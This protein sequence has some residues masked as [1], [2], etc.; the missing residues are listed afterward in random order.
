M[1][2]PNLTQLIN[3]ILSTSICNSNR[4]INRMRRRKKEI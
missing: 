4:I 2:L 3:R 1:N